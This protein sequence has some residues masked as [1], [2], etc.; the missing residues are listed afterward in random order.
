MRLLLAS[1]IHLEFRRGAIMPELPPEDTYDAVLLAGDIGIGVQAIEW[2]DNFFPK[3]K[4]VYYTPGNH[5]FY[6]QHMQLT[7]QRMQDLCD[8]CRVTLL[9]PGAVLL[10]DKKHILIGA[11]LWTDLHLQ[12]Y[13]LQ[14][15][16]RYEWGI[17]DFSLIQYENFLF[18]ADHARELY[19]RDRAIIENQ[20]VMAKEHGLIPVIMTHFVPTQEAIAP[21]FLGDSLTPYFVNDCDDLME[22]YDLPIWIFGHSHVRMDFTHSRH[23]TRIISNAFGYPGEMDE[24]VWKII[25]L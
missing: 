11:T 19:K 21:Q 1:D 17:A 16:N 6:R 25:Q 22:L 24:P 2:A 18:S 13:E 23:G 4:L 9:A 12:G 7:L 14:P 20:I 3:D 8:K 10:E 15:D 5:E